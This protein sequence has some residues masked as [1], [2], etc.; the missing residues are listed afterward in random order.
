[1][2]IMLGNCSHWQVVKLQLLTL[3]TLY[4]FS[5]STSLRF[6]IT[7][8]SKFATDT[9]ADLNCRSGM[10]L[11][12]V[13]IR[14]WNQWRFHCWW[15]ISKM[16]ICLWRMSFLF[17]QQWSSKAKLITLQHQSFIN[18]STWLTIYLEKKNEQ[19][20]AVI[21]TFSQMICSKKYSILL[22]FGYWSCPKLGCSL[23]V[24]QKCQKHRGCWW[25]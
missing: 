24:E 25:K 3:Q 1:M 9:R 15:T 11:L 22:A 17:F 5:S 12:E 7:C 6:E 16:F 23:P 18:A 19:H 14:T 10:F 13:E 8:E 4:G 20:G 2:L 21:E